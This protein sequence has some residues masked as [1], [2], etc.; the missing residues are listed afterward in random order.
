MDENLGRAYLI[1]QLK[2]HDYSRRRSLRVLNC[3]FREINEALARGEEVEF[4]GGRLVRVDPASVCRLD[5]VDWPAHWPRWTV[6]WV[7][8]W[9]TLVGLVGVEEAQKRALDFLFDEVFI[10]EWQA[11]ERGER[12]RAAENRKQSQGKFGKRLKS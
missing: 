12:K 1:E 10:G 9:E 8:R 2:K 11:W 3:L 5:Y 7:P 6:K 4:A